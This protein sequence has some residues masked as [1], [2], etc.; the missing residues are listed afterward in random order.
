MKTVIAVLVFAV[1]FV[2]CGD[3]ENI[4][5]NLAQ[6]N[7]AVAT[8][9]EQDLAANGVSGDVEAMCRPIEGAHTCDIFVTFID[10]KRQRLGD[11]ENV[12]RTDTGITWDHE[13]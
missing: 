3:D 12:R 1:L 5:E 11:A 9:M 4:S 8:A 2:G 10:G 13:S 7:N 6:F